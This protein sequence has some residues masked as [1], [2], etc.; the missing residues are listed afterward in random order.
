MEPGAPAAAEPHAVV[1]LSEAGE[2]IPGRGIERPD[3]VLAHSHPPFSGSGQLTSEFTARPAWPGPACCRLSALGVKRIRRGWT[4]TRDCAVPDELRERPGTGGCRVAA[5]GALAVE[6][7]LVAS[8]P[9]TLPDVSTAWH[10]RACSARVARQY[11]SVV[12]VADLASALRHAVH[13]DVVAGSAWTADR[14]RPSTDPSRARSRART[15]S[16]ERRRLVG[17]VGGVVV[18]G[19]GGVVTDDGVALG[20]RCRSRRGRSDPG[21]RRSSPASG[22]GPERRARSRSW[23]A[24]YGLLVGEERV[25]G[26]SRRRRPTPSRR[27]RFASAST[28]VTESVGASSGASCR[29]AWCEV[30]VLLGAGPV[31]GRGRSR[32]RS[33]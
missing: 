9:T 11:T 25:A 5:S 16:G 26:L 4:A 30:T 17:A 2:G 14:C 6:D 3:R 18:G 8:A 33:S 15:A 22:R 20:A 13:V 31:P 12:A 23:S 29:A 1:L 28:P 27:P 7:D 10:R 24:P 32:S 19:C 21:A